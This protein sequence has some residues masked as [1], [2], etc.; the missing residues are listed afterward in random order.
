VSMSD[1]EKFLQQLASDPELAKKDAAAHRRE[2]VGL[3][4]E[5][6]FEVT[7]AELAEASRA[8]QDAP[9]GTIDDEALEAVV[10]GGGPP[11]DWDPNISFN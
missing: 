8:V 2:L 4:R 10:G 9:Y 1:A 7:E 3:A 6:G 5:K 11:L